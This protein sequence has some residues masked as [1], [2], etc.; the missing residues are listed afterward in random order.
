[1]KR[2]PLFALG[3]LLLSCNQETGAEK[4]PSCDPSNETCLFNNAQL[5]YEDIEGTVPEEALS[6]ETNLLLANFSTSQA[7]KIDQAIEVIKRVVASEEFKKAILNH[8]FE[9]K[10]TFVSNGGLSNLQIYHR[11]LLG[12]EELT[13]EFNNTLDAELELYTESN[14]TVGYTNPGTKRIWMNTKYFNYYTPVQV[15][16]NLTHE[17]MHKLGFGH[18]QTS[19][20]SRPYSV[21]YAFGTIM[22]NLGVEL[23]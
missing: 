11:F 3:L 18:T 9:G 1:M 20:A 23:P 4:G 5:N 19:T 7:E 22:N 2:I 13:P 12:A 17:W 21:P 10:K 14:Q 15:A 8:A 16:G 6:F